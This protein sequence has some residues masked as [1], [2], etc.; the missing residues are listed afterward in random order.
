MIRFKVWDDDIELMMGL[1]GNIRIDQNGMCF[2]YEEKSQDIFTW[3]EQPNMIP[4]QYIGINDRYK[5]SIYEGDIVD[6]WGTEYNG[7]KIGE[8]LRQK[9]IRFRCMFVF[10]DLDIDPF[11]DSYKFSTFM[12][13]EDMVRVGSIYENPELL[14]EETK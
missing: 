11:Q 9:V 2:R 5:Q 3:V 6:I 7:I 10:L 13:G 4:L 1:A 8:F 14:E 12:N